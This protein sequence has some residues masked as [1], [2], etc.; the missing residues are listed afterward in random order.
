MKYHHRYK[1][2]ILLLFIVSAVFLQGCDWIKGQMGMP[3]SKDI[4][5]MKE[6]I[7]LHEEQKAALAKR[8]QAV[9]DSLARSQA[10][11]KREITGYHVVAGCFKDFSNAE[12]LEKKLKGKGYANALQ[13]PLKN[14]YMMVS[15]GSMEKLGEAIRLMEKISADPDIQF[16]EEVWVYNASQKLHKEN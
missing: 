13:I 6:E 10:E 5:Q 11:A 15:L 4:E 1:R 7:R 16:F 12:R 2:T 9:R 3:T 8:E 14:G